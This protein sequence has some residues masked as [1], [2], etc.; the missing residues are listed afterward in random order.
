MEKQIKKEA[1][2]LKKSV[3][4]DLFGIS[5]NKNKSDKSQKVKQS[6]RQK[7]VGK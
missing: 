3:K 4:K 7:R 1:I 2:D 6:N 5:K